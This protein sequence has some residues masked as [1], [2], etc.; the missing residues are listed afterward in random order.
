MKLKEMIEN[1]KELHPDVSDQRIIKLLNQANIEFCTDTRVSE[2]SY[3]I[4]GGTVKDKTYYTLD[5]AI[6]GIN[7]VYINGERAQRL[8]V[9][10][11]KEDE[12][13]T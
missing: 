8:E 12:D 3:L 13:M 9:K 11:D 1:I 2:A 6:I 7:E 10:P 5:D 4:S